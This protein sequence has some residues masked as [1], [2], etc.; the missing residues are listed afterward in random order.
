METNL[1]IA[2]ENE[3]TYRDNAIARLRDQQAKERKLK[4]KGR[5]HNPIC[6]DDLENPEGLFC[7]GGQCAQEYEQMKKTGAIDKFRTLKV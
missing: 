6:D 2:S 7:P 1:D 4:P 3:Q 5:C